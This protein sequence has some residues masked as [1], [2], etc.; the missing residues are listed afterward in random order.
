ME[1]FQW[2]F[3]LAA[4]FCFGGRLLRVGLLEAAVASQAGR[5]YDTVSLTAQV[6]PGVLDGRGANNIASV[7]EDRSPAMRRAYQPETAPLPLRPAV[8][9]IGALPSPRTLP[10]FFFLVQR[11]FRRAAPTE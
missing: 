9:L 8:P 5:F 1:L 6:L 2:E 10:L 3:S 7:R 11:L 4:D